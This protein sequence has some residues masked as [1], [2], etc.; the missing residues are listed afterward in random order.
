MYPVQQDGGGPLGIDTVAALE[1]AAFATD[2]FQQ[3]KIVLV[4]NGKKKL[5]KLPARRL[6]TGLVLSTKTL[7]ISPMNALKMLAMIS[8]FATFMVRR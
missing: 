4:L 1:T 2:L 8:L 5:R 6:S 3:F 7:L